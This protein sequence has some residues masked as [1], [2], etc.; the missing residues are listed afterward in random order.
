MRIKN[1]Y[2]KIIF[3][4]N[5]AFTPTNGWSQSKKCLLLSSY[6]YEYEW[7]KI[8][9]DTAKKSLEKDQVCVIKEFYLDSIRKKNLEDINNKA[10]E[11]KKLIETWKPDVTIAIDDNASRYVVAP[12]FRNSQRKFVF[13]GVNWSVK[14]YGYPYTNATGM[15]E[16]LPLKPLLENSLKI[17]NYNYKKISGKAKS[18]ACVTSNRTSDISQCLHIMKMAENKPYNLSVR[19][20]TP[21]NF[22][23]WK[24][25]FKN[26]QEKSDI[27]IFHNYQGIKDWNNH[28]ARIFVKE[29]IKKITATTESWMKDLNMFTIEKTATEQGEYA[30]KTAIKILNG[31]RPI[32]IPIIPN[33]RWNFYST[34]SLL[35]KIQVKIPPSIRNKDRSRK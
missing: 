11:V 7:N 10:Q 5:I 9:V 2:I 17:F 24:S 35:D 27:V 28:R 31:E 30:A 13:C 8:I 20:A 29:H 6:H 12:Y 21:A 33:R 25:D 14:E 1:W 32:D 23:D 19:L 26:V 34:K 3:T 16:V 15:I 4:L 22:T 18:L